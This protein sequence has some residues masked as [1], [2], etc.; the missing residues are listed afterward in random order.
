MTQ[1]AHCFHL[2]NQFIF[3]SLTMSD[4]DSSQESTSESE[5]NERPLDNPPNINNQTTNFQCFLVISYQDFKLGIAFYRLGSDKLE[6][7][8]E[9]HEYYDFNYIK[10]ILHKVQP[11]DVIISSKVDTQLVNY[12]KVFSLSI[13]ET[14]QDSDADVPPNISIESDEYVYAAYD[15]NPNTRLSAR[16][17]LHILSR[18]FFNYDSCKNRVLS[19][20]LPSIANM[21]DLNERF[22]YLTANIN[23]SETNTLKSLGVLLYFLEKNASFNYPNFSEFGYF[24]FYYVTMD[25]ATYDSLEIFQQEW[26]PSTLKKGIYKKEGLSVFGIFN[27][28]A[29]KLGSFYLKKIFQQPITD[30]ASLN[31]RQDVIEFFTHP[32]SQ[33]IKDLL[34][35][36]L[37]HV[38]DISPIINRFKASTFKFCDFEVLLGVISNMIFIRN[39]IANFD[40]KF[41]LFSQ[42]TRAFTEE[43]E[44][45]CQCLQTTIDFN[46]SSEENIEINTKIDTKLDEW[47][48]IF[49]KL[50]EVLNRVMVNESDEDNSILALQFRN[51]TNLYVPQIGFLLAVPLVEAQKVPD[52]QLFGLEA[53]FCANDRVFCKNKKTKEFDTYYGDIVFNIS[54]QSRKVLIGCRNFIIERKKTIKA[55]TSL[56]AQLDAMIAMADTASK[57]KY[58]RPTLN[59]CGTTQ[60]DDGRHPL[61]ELLDQSFVPNPFSSSEDDGKICIVFG[62]NNCGKSV[63][64]KQVSLIIYL[65]HIGSFVPA[66]KADIKIVDQIFTRIRTPESIS[67]QLSAFK[68]DLNQI[69]M[70][71]KYASKHS[72]VVIDFF[73]KGTLSID[74]F[75]LLSSFIRHWA[76]DYNR[77]HIIISS[78]FYLK[79]ELSHLTEINFFTFETVNNMHTY[80]LIRCDN[81]DSDFNILNSQD[82]DTMRPRMEAMLTEEDT[83]DEDLQAA[84]PELSQKYENLVGLGNFILNQN[85]L[86]EEVYDQIYQLVDSIVDK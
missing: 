35:E 13:N 64:L 50:P 52:L 66:K 44:E 85:S 73:G 45:I 61:Y 29:S 83:L 51:L 62:P 69:I 81:A 48:V 84:F 36:H 68:H 65:A 46:N 15:R 6:L 37:K 3:N 71:I 22:I 78:Q 23:F 9:V 75:S 24:N 11:T 47:K 67:S 43:L 14:E 55:S 72:F 60:I 74:G 58:T 53:I 31:Q 4:V 54:E 59:V 70:A 26:H 57:Y 77:P 12:L 8:H 19:M 20:N 49:N 16:F 63:Y 41:N 30:F 17:K 2:Q 34:N 5:S 21:I 28:C 18:R 38:K 82:F 10:T 56:C 80:S 79:A 86:N 39:I 42:I 33:N 32:S 1:T 7:L 25:Q 27:S 40:K 76:E